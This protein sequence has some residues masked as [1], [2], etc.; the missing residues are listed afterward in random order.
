MERKG[1]ARQLGKSSMRA[2]QSCTV[3]I[4]LRYSAQYQELPGLAAI[5][6]GCGYWPAWCRRRVSGCTGLELCQGGPSL[7]VPPFLSH[8]PKSSEMDDVVHTSG[9]PQP[10]CEKQRKSE[11]CWQMA[12]H[13]H[14]AVH[15]MGFFCRFLATGVHCLAT[16]VNPYEAPSA[17]PSLLCLVEGLSWSILGQ[18]CE[19]RWWGVPGSPKDRSCKRT[20]FRHCTGVQRPIAAGR[21]PGQ[22]PTSPSKKERLAKVA[23]AAGKR[24]ARL[25]CP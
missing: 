24:V 20:T 8:S 18:Y 5:S 7:A 22:V 21:G 11:R 15:A 23:A 17:S 10:I 19:F 1:R 2:E 12:R 14:G 16:Y 9:T 6:S 13:W 25:W 3:T 4:V